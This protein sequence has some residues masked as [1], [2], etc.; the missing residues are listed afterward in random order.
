MSCFGQKHVFRMIKVDLHQDISRDTSGKMQGFRKAMNAVDD[1][2]HRGQV[3][4][5]CSYK[6]TSLGAIT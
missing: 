5:K 6:I 1:S 3:G 2:F 4:Q